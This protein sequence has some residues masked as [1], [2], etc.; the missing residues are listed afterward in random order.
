MPSRPRR[1]LS[2]L[3][4]SAAFAIWFVSVL[5]YTVFMECYRCDICDPFG[6]P[7]VDRE[8]NRE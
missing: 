3:F 8:L 5:C 7:V 2:T 4:G 6:M 1:E